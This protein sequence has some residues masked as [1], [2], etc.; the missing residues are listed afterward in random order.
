LL[1]SHG[2]QFDIEKTVGL[3]GTVYQRIV[4]NEPGK[5]HVVVDDI[6]RE[7]LALSVGGDDIESFCIIRVVRVLDYET[8]IV[9]R[10]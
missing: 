10:V 5:I 6:T 1:V 7:L 4:G 8:V 3:V 2:T 9:Q